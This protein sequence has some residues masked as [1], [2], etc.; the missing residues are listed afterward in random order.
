[1]LV[2]AGSSGRGVLYEFRELDGAFK[3]I[4]DALNR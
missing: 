2:H 1:L 3:I 4:D